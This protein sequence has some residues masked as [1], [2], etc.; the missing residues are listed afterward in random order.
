MSTVVQLEAFEA[1]IRGRQLRWFLAPNA[2]ISYPPGFQ[3]QC[4]I[5]SPP[6]Q[7]KVLLTSSNSSEAWCLV[8]Q[9][10]AILKPVSG[11]D[12]SIALSLL[13]NQPYPCIV[14]S[15]PELKVPQAFFQKCKQAGQKAPT[16]V[17]FQVLKMPVPQSP[18]SFDATFFPP[19][20]VLED[21]CHEAATS[22]LQQTL[23]SDSFRQFS[24]KDAVRDL[25]G[26]GATLIVSSIE[27]PV[28]TLYWYYAAPHKSEGKSLL[29][30]VVQTLLL[31]SRE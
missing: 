7:R 27:D 29:A 24:I 15:T 3:E 22:V 21:I 26:A 1:Q 8:E 18:C 31:R 4:F 25:K 6:F 20:T 14:C 17:W 28:P 11:V 16:F 19:S 30:S 5:E 2:P 10:D 12:W 9:W 13:L 23:P